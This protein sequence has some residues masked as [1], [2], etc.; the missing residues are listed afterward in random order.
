[1]TNNSIYLD[2]LTITPIM[3][4]AID[5]MVEAMHGDYGHIRST[6]EPGRKSL[7]YLQAA[8][9]ILAGY[10]GG[11]STR[12]YYDG[13]VANALSLLSVA[14]IQKNKGRSH[15][16]ASPIEHASIVMALRMLKNEGFS[17]SFTSIEK[18]SLRVTPEMLE[19]EIRDDTGI[20]TI[21]MA[22][23]E[24]GVIQPVEALSEVI[25]GKDILFHCDARSAAG[26]LPVNVRQ[27]GIDILTI[28][29]HKFGGPFAVGAAVALSGNSTIFNSSPEFSGVVNIPGIAGLIA[30]LRVLDTG[31]EA[32]AR[33]MNHLRSEVIQGL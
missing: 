1:M 27:A 14:K 20:V 13:G 4:E 21:G 2:N 31:I 25:S 12:F 29:S 24:S 18:G 3:D 17:V 10:F 28:A 6:N 9:E 30:T 32:R 15:I 22:S 5:A 8:E 33:M 19:D 16:V 11:G 26:R 7:E 23:D